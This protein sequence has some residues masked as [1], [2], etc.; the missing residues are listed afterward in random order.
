MSHTLHESPGQML[1]E[2]APPLVRQMVPAPEALCVRR[3]EPAHCERSSAGAAAGVS[4]VLDSCGR[5]WRLRDDTLWEST[6]RVITTAQ[7]LEDAYGPT[8]P[9]PTT[10]PDA[11]LTGASAAPVGARAGTAHQF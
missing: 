1:P 7:L 3:P 2:P 9:A 6:D 4:A 10:A 8:R 5:L 11:V